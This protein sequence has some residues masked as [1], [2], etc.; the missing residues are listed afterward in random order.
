MGNKL[1][2]P[3]GQN[4]KPHR[5]GRRRFGPATVGALA[6]LCLLIAGS[7]YTALTPDG[8]AGGAVDLAAVAQQPRDSAP[9][10]ADEHSGIETGTVP[11]RTSGRSGADIHEELTGDGLTVTTFRPGARESDGPLVLD[12]GAPGQDLRVAHLPEE[13]LLEETAFGAIPTVGPGGKRPV[14]AYARSWSQTRGAR[15]AIVVGGLGLSQ[16]GTQYAIQTLPEE[17]TLAFAAS[18]NSLTRWRQEARRGGHAILLQVPMEPFNYPAVDPGRDT[19][20]IDAGADDNLADLHRSMARITNYTG[21]MNYMGGRFMAD[22]EAFEPVMRDIA[23][24]GLLFLDDGSG[25]QSQAGLLARTL[26]APFAEAEIVLDARR[27][28][29]AILQSLDALER[30]AIRHGAAIGVASAFDTSV[31]VIAEWITNASSRNIEI[32][33]VAAIATDPE[34]ARAGN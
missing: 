27:E 7:L 20:T 29:G 15:I 30:S 32:V 12:G 3:L 6:G 8:I 16:T 25:S 21:I 11:A 10:A 14:D 9:A 2:T 26:G 23:D 17:V 4:R 22:A 33:G 31:D 1:D 13:G 28:R 34:I 19:L 5:A 24:R 18:G